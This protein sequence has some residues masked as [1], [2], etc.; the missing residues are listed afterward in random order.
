MVLS[1]QSVNSKETYKETMKLIFQKF[2]KIVKNGDDIDIETDGSGLGLY[3]SKEIV[4]LHSG[5]ILVKSEGKN[6]GSTFI[7]K[8]PRSK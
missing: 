5:Q 8:L 7:V 4:E 1:D 2:G 3:I 6:K